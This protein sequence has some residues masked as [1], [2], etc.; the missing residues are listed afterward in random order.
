[1]LSF[2]GRTVYNLK[3]LWEY[4]FNIQREKLNW[5]EPEEFI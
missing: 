1:M 2:Q 5:K 4:Q 3:D